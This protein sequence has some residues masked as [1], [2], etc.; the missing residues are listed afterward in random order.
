MEQQDRVEQF[1][2]E[3]AEMGL[4]DPV[5]GRERVLVVVGAILMIG[6]P[7]TALAAYIQSSGTND[8]LQQG[9]D[10]IIALI[11]VA[12]TI[13]GAAL[14]IRYSIGSFLRFWLA[15]L[16]YDQHTQTERLI[17]ALAPDGSPAQPK[18]AGQ[19]KSAPPATVSTP[20]VT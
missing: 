18:A 14:F 12:V 13:L 4:R 1:K 2:S 20:S 7:I 3:I 16:S 9:D 17:D 10:H 5:T 8:P 6:G 15:R 19:P 11:G